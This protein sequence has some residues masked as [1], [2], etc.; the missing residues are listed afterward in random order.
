MPLIL[1]C[2]RGTLTAEHQHQLKSMQEQIH[3]LWGNG[4]LTA[5]RMYSSMQSGDFYESEQSTTISHETIARIVY[6]SQM[7][8][9]QY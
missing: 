7:E 3:I 1:S 6:R 5:N 8:M 4:Q 2:E 9:K